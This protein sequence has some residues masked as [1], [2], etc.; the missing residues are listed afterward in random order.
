MVQKNP[1]NYLLARWR[2]SIIFIIN[3]ITQLLS[4]LLNVGEFTFGHF[5]LW[6]SRVSRVGAGLGSIILLLIFFFR[7]RSLSLFPLRRVR[8]VTMLLRIKLK[9]SLQGSHPIRR[10]RFALRFW[11]P[12]F[13]AIALSI[14]SFAVIGVW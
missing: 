4:A 14:G 6:P 11:P 3:L 5:A 1:K 10:L 12:A 8:R 7:W 13:L 9:A 2:P